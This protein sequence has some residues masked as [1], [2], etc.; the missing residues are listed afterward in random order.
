MFATG[1]GL[2]QNLSSLFVPDL[3]RTLGITRGAIATSAALGLLGALAAPAIGRQAD[4]I[5]VRP[6]LLASL[7]LVVCGHLVFAL[8][9]GPAWQF[10]L[11]I[12][13][14]ALSAPGLGSLVFGR[15][16]A[17]RFDQHR[18]A[19]L[20]LALTIS[21]VSTFL[22]PPLIG[23]VIEEYGWRPAYLL[24]AV[25][26]V[27]IGLPPALIAIRSAGERSGAAAHAHGPAHA[28]DDDEPR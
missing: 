4:R 11:G 7:A 15:L 5:G 25:L 21:S 9:A 14:L 26:P 24:L 23:W 10:Q 17:R 27:L 16:I 28:A 3:E 2:Y 8:M 19:A 22:L 12:A 20:G 6:V 1:P 18:G 13:L